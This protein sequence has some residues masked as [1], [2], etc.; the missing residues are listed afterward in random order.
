MPYTVGGGGVPPPPQTKVT[1]VG[2]NEIYIR[3]NL[4]GPFLVPD[5]PPPPKSSG[6]S[7]DT[8]KT[9]SGPQR[10]RRCSGERPI[11]AA[12]GKQSDA[13]A[14][15]Q[16]QPPSPSS[17]TPLPSSAPRP[18]PP[19][20]VVLYMVLLLL[21]KGLYVLRYR[22]PSLEMRPIFWNL[23]ILIMTMAARSLRG[24]EYI[25]F[26]FVIILVVVLAQIYRSTV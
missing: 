13:E 1:I 11:G 23:L 7:V 5:P 9:R 4:M 26:P 6:G 10:V 22:I 20:S 2:K 8:T 18:I 17:N 15:C 14:L 21:A 25:S 12:K 19:R 3:E 24:S 16:P